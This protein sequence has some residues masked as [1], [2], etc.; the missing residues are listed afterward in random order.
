MR[1]ARKEKRKPS[2]A[3]SALLTRKFSQLSAES[4]PSDHCLRAAAG[5]GEGGVGGGAPMDRVY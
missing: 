1:F 3:A 2:T 4:N 5:G